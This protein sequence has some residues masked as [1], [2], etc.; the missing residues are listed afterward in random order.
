M[1]H[2]LSRKNINNFR[3]ADDTTVMA[4]SKE[5]LKN[6]LMRVKDES[7]KASLKPNIKKTNIMTSSPITSWQIEG[8]KVERVTDF[9]FLGS[10]I[11]VDGGWLQPWNQ[12]TIASRQESDDKP[13]RCAE[14]QRHYS[15]DKGPYS[16]GYG[17]SSG[18]VLV[19]AGW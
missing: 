19:R 6:L 7:E 17:L 9:P 16:K 3:Y 11:T 1:N 12:K 18:Y 5:E 10:K 4:E 14:K 2:K 8:E 13:R 15:A